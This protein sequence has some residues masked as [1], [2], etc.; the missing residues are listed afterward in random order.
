MRNKAN[1]SELV[2][3]NRDMIDGCTD[4]GKSIS[5]QRVCLVNDL[6]DKY[7]PSPW[8]PFYLALLPSRGWGGYSSPSEIRRPGTTCLRIMIRTKK[9]KK[10]Q[11][12]TRSMI[13]PGEDI[14]NRC[15]D[16]SSYL[17]VERP[18]QNG[19]F[20]TTTL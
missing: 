1:G 9:E 11:Y 2:D 4:A 6:L 19:F 15:V 5:D 7:V 8:G 3:E 16:A 14:D 13:S 20:G 17:E 10:K 18:V 12:A